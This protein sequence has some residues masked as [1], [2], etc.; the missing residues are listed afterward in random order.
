MRRLRTARLAAA[1]GGGTCANP[2]ARSRSRD[3][4]Q[5]QRRRESP[6]HFEL[7]DGLGPATSSSSRWP[8]TDL[9]A[10]VGRH[11]RAEGEGDGCRRGR[12]RRRDP[13]RR[14]TSNGSSLPMWCDGITMIPQGYGGYSVESVNEPVTCAG[15]E[16][17]P[18]DLI[19]ADS[20]GV[21]VIPQPKR[22]RS[23]RSPKR[24]KPRRS[25]HARALP[26]GTPLESLYPS[27]DYYRPD[28]G[29]TE[30]SD[31]TLAAWGA[32]LRP[33]FGDV[34]D[35]AGIA[36]RR[37][38]R[39]APRRSTSRRTATP[40]TCACRSTHPRRSS[41]AAQ[42]QGAGGPRRRRRSDRHRR[43]DQARHPRAQRPRH[44]ARGRR[45]LDARL[46]PLAHAAHRR[47][48]TRR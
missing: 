32:F 15:V 38:P 10:S 3:R 41:R 35:E 44:G 8:A 1:P 36:G 12:R 9:L 46:D 42:P 34:L 25:A 4:A 7:V 26:R 18:G 37:R 19:V 45:R 5:R 29:G 43:R 23:R 21:I 30:V 28:R 6:L 31:L 48:C 40:C 33:A 47:R 39:Q 24:S 20:D 17:A 16:V 27:R 11:A 2:A 13:R 14:A 22:S